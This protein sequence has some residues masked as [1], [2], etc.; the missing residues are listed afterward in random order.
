MR[1]VREAAQVVMAKR[2]AWLERGAALKK[3]RLE[4]KRA[5]RDA[6]EGTLTD[7]WRDPPAVFD[8]MR[9]FTARIMVNGLFALYVADQPVLD[10]NAP[11]KDCEL[12]AMATEF[13]APTDWPSSSPNS[14]GPRKSRRV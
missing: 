6:A 1:S 12:H 9:F 8:R 10:P 14:S 4:T 3:L 13:G 2:D 5:I 11:G 7:P